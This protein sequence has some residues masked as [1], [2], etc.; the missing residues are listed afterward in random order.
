MNNERP[1]RVTE[2]FK[3]SLDLYG[4]LKMSLSVKALQQLYD[5]S[6]DR[7]DIYGGIDIG[8]KGVKATVIGVKLNT[9]GDYAFE[10]VYNTSINTSAAQCASFDETR[11]VIVERRDS[12]R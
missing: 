12:L 5:G 7:N 8:A 4:T 6:S 1:V 10:Q 11:C 3:K 2:Y 9:T